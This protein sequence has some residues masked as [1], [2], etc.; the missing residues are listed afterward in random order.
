MAA[1]GTYGTKRPAYITSNDVEILYTYRPDRNTDSTEFS[2]N[3]YKKL[4]SDIL[5]I[6]Q[7]ESSTSIPGMYNIKLPLDKF[8]EAGIYTIYIRPKE[9]S[10]TISDVSTLM[11]YP[12]VRG[13]IIN[14]GDVSDITDTSIFN[15]GNLVGYR[16]EYFGSDGRMD[17]YRLITSNN[18]C[19]P[20]NQNSTVSSNNGT[21]YRLND[22][23]TSL[24]FCTLTPST[25]M[26]FKPNDTPFIGN[27]GQQIKL[28]NTKFDPICIELELTEHD[29]ES[30]ATMLEGDQIRDLNNNRITT[31]DKN[32]EIY[33]Q[34][35]CGHVVDK[36]DGVNADFKIKNVGTIIESDK[37]VLENIKAS[38]E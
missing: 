34:A 15:N 36:N 17:E 3:T 20:V 26:S 4:D 35:D 33:H 22:S 37:D 5:T 8:G 29:I 30:V 1:N 12:N 19:I 11:A 25:A 18:K 27:I 38:L 16:V 2:N 28:I 32:G 7:D 9:I 14:T 10:C 13:I 23:N 6:V 24:I 21:K 31:F